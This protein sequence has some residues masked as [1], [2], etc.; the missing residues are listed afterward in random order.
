MVPC[1]HSSVATA[2]LLTRVL[3]RAERESQQCLDLDYEKTLP[4]LL[5]TSLAN[6]GEE[7]KHMAELIY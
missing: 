5:K 4:L 3:Q 6:T 1:E 7:G 2:A